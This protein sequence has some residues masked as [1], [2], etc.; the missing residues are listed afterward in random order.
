MK[1]LASKLIA[2][3]FL[4]PSLAVAIVFSGSDLGI[5]VF[6]A[7]V[8]AALYW[9]FILRPGNLSFWQLAAKYPDLVYQHFLK[10]ECWFIDEMP[11]NIDKEDI[12]G[13]FKLFVPKL[14]RSITIYGIADQID[15][16]QA[17]LMKLTRS[18]T[19]D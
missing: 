9:F 4:L 13:P 11:T 8:S 7:V 17:E 5:L 6:T 18:G 1:T 14:G 15:N 3:S 10:E 16:S 19:T 2:L 12:V